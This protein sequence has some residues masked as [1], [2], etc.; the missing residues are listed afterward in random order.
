[1][2]PFKVENIEPSHV[3]DTTNVDVEVDF[4]PSLDYDEPITSLIIALNK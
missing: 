4:L 1:M 2:I 3:V